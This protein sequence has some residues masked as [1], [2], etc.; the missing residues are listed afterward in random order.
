MH[1]QDII[2]NR[3]KL[4]D[5]SKRVV[6]DYIGILHCLE[7][8][9]HLNNIAI[10]YTFA[11]S[12]EDILS[13]LKGSCQLII[14]KKGLSL[15]SYLH[16]KVNIIEFNE[17]QLPIDIDP[18]ILQ[19]ISVRKLI[20][21]IE[22]LHYI[23]SFQRITCHNFKQVISKAEVYGF[24]KN[25]KC[26]KERI[27][28]YYP[29]IK[30]YDDILSIGDIWGRYIYFNFRAGME[31]DNELIS[32]VDAAAGK[33]IL[34]GI[35]KD[36]FYESTDNLK[37]V[38]RVVKYI[39]SK[40]N[41]KIAL[42]CFD[43]MGVA[44]WNLLKEYL[45]EDDFSFSEKYVFALVPTMTKI[46]RSSIFYGNAEKIYEITSPNE[47]KAFKEILKDNSV[48]AYREGQLQSDEQLL[49]IDVVKI[50]YNI[51]DDVA[52]KT[53]L[54]PSVKNKGVYFMNV[55]NYLDKSTIKNE[56]MML[57][58]TG[59]KIW[60]CSDHGCVVAAG[61]GQIIDKYLIETSS[62]RAT[63]IMKREL[64]KFYDTDT[65]QIPFV[66]DKI[67]LLARGRTSFSHKN[68]IEIAHGGITLDELIVPLVEVTS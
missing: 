9:K 16:T 51:F 19:D 18:Q 60:I 17:K 35:L 52:H 2:L 48:G 25:T 57:K 32:K 13:D 65:Y 53:T 38:D 11:Q 12:V 40:S 59:Y 22:Y 26:L 4:N 55:R 58:E 46:S 63:I 68:K 7:F 8:K 27:T 14:A 15:P 62:K 45:T 3:L 43:G 41:S 50:I 34:N 36:C 33:L 20:Q 39:L 56:L 47:D 5:S 24:E 67:V 1:W 49:G 30:T 37:T 61:S 23:K 66:K 21:L 28:N 54:P 64:S 44:E 29:V 31:P 6:I 10:K 42:V